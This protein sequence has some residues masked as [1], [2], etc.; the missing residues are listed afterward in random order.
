MAGAADFPEFET[1]FEAL[2]GA[3]QAFKL[4]ATDGH[5][6]AVKFREKAQSGA[7]GLASELLAASLAAAAGVH[8]PEAKVMLLTQE[9]LDLE[10]RVHFH[11]QTRPA[12]GIAS[13]SRFL[14]PA[15][16][17]PGDHTARLAVCPPSDI[18]GV[19]VFNT[20]VGCDDRSWNN[21][22][23]T[24]DGTVPRFA[25]I[26]YATAFGRPTDAT[27]QIAD[28]AEV[29]AAATLS[30]PDVERTLGRVEGLSDAA[31]GIA[32]SSIPDE[33]W[34]HA[35]RDSLISMLVASRSK[36][37]LVVERIKP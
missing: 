1:F 34:S 17:L 29:Q 32:A 27:L 33:F 21:Y 2:P 19:L 6:Y 14:P 12:P 37:R 30:W 18:A 25:S 28:L 36:V 11:D 10:P 4:G 7:L 23:F 13:G 5:T 22:A 31:I 9:Y 16:N 26:D 15:E 24:V 8:V 35:E 3:S 20:W